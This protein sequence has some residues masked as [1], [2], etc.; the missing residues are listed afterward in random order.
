MWRTAQ[1]RQCRRAAG[2][3]GPLQT[4]L[5]PEPHATGAATPPRRSLA[6]AV[7]WR[8]VRVA[9]RKEG[10]CRRHATDEATRP[11]QTGLRPEPHAN[12]PRGPREPHSASAR[13]ARARLG[14]TNRNAIQG[15]SGRG[16]RLARRKEGAAR[17][18]VTDAATSSDGAAPRTPRERS[19]GTPRAPLRVREART[20]APR[21]A[22]TGGSNAAKTIPRPCGFLARRSCGKAQ[23]GSMQAACDRRSNAAKTIPR[24]CGFL[25]RRSCGKAQGGSMQAACDRRSNAATRTPRQET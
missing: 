8:G 10:A 16:V 20:C 25:A 2:T 23:G 22:V 18:A 7:S 15:V 12:A 5:R 6:H 19:A 4:G 1:A 9:R 11:L 21:R 24:P 14:G 3:G 17:R 13:R